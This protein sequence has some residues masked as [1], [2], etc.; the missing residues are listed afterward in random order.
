MSADN[1]M[2]WITEHVYDYG[3][4]LLGPTSNWVVDAFPLLYFIRKEEGLTEQEMKTRY[5][6]ARMRVHGPECKGGFG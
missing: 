6:Q 2:D 4:G 3:H 5:D 1:L